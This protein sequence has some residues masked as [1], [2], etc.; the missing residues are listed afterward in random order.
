MNAESVTLVNKIIHEKFEVPMDKLIPEANL[1][2]DLQLDSLDFVDMVVL[3]E[4]KVRMPV[5]DIDITKIV[6]LGDVY[7]LVEQ[8]SAKQ[9]T[10]N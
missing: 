8:I 7:N 2:S 9:K 3:L 1:R 10:L 6:S 5:Q 4:Q